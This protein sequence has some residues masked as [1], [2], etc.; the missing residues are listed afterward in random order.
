MT[1]RLPKDVHEN[2]SQE[3]YLE[4][5]EQYKKHDDCRGRSLPGKLHDPEDAPKQPRRVHTTNVQKRLISDLN[6]VRPLLSLSTCREILVELLLLSQ[7]AGVNYHHGH[8]EEADDE[9][10][11]CIHES[12]TL[13]SVGS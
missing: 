1:C 3:T 10:G 13:Y 11:Y 7:N 9:P 2:S 6:A 12:E 8:G 5:E 4:R